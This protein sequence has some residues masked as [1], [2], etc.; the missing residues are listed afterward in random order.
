MTDSTRSTIPAQ[1]LHSLD[2][3]LLFQEGISA[4]PSVVI[5]DCQSN[6]QV[7]IKRASRNAFPYWPINSIVL[8]NTVCVQD[9]IYQALSHADEHFPVN[10]CVAADSQ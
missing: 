2:I 1:P 5:S 4:T 10:P 8:L 6:E 7:Q 3:A 9:Y